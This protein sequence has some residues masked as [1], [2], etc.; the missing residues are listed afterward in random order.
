[1]AATPHSARVFIAVD[2]PQDYEESL[3]ILGVYGSLA[4]AQTAVRLH[5]ARPGN[6]IRWAYGRRS[7]V[8]EWVGDEHRTTWAFHPD[9]GWNTQPAAP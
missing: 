7:E 9:R 1:M 8:Q 2:P 6:Q 3:D 4:A 5:R